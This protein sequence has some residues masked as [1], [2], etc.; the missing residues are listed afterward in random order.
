M[1]EFNDFIAGFGL[2]AGTFI[3][4]FLSGFIPIFNA[5]AWLVAVSA[6]SPLHVAIPLIILSALGQMSAKI[7][8]FLAGRSGRKIPAGKYKDK[9]EQ[10]REKFERW[11]GRS[12]LFV[13][14]SASTGFP[15]FYVISFLVGVLEFGLL[16]FAFV[17]LAGRLLR[18]GVFVYFPQLFKIWF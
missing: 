12:D 2:Y 10:T 18:F 7:L 6:I 3:F 4:C 8:V 1:I 15:P 17:G 14:I 9:I 16:R 13:F 11:R 5:E